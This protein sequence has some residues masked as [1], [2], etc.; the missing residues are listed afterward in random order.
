M[1][2]GFTVVEMLVVLSIIGTIT[3]IVIFNVGSQQRNSA[4][5]RSAQN[6]SLNLRRVENFALS[7]KIFKTSGVPCGWGIH[8]NGVGSTSYIIFA[9]KAMNVNCSDR[10]FTRAADGSEDFENI[11]LDPQITISSLGDGLSDVIFSPPEPSVVFVPNQTTVG[12]ILSNR[13]FATREVRINKTGFI[14]SPQ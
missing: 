1:N 9:D 11:K 13:D 12:I 6:L 4:L 5:L 3:G 10:D 8:F 14:S 2:K 7:S